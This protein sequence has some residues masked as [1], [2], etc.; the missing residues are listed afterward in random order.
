VA[1]TLNYTT[2][3]TWQAD[4]VNAGQVD[5]ALSELRA[6]EERA[7]VR[8][9]VLTLVAV[10]G[11]GRETSETLD[12]VRHLG[13]RHP[14]RTLVL[15]L[16][17]D[18]QETGLDASAAVRLVERDGR[19]VAVEEVILEVRGKAR[20]HLD[21]LV[22]PFTIPDLP[23][24][25]WLP[26]N[27]PGRGDPLVEAADRIII[28]TRVVGYRPDALSRLVTLTKRLPVTDL[29]WFRLKPWRS[30]LASLFEGRVY[31]PFLDDVQHIEVTG[32]SGPRHMLAG[33]LMS[34]LNLPRAVVHLGE[35]DHVAIK[36]V[37]ANGGRTG[38]FEVERKGDEHVIDA[39]VEIDDGPS[40][41]QKVQF[42]K[43]WPSRALAD[44]LTRMGHD[45]IYEEALGAAVGLLK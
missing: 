12:I 11:D 28:D 45:Q 10:V 5:V 22:L 36:L 17:E 1:E 39:S 14:S 43:D 9:S 42:G 13:A 16:D 30:L 37:A 7:A 4:S 15:V 25:I 18:S 44:A 38:R 26:N 21:S 40:F 23:V 31:R 32:R 41:Q 3:G 24:A 19:E 27:L 33:W 29:S 34:R 6:H 2:L 8:T 20:H 35:A